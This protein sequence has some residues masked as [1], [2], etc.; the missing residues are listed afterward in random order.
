[1]TMIPAY[2]GFPSHIEGAE[3]Q[4][5]GT[6]NLD[7]LLLNVPPA[8]NYACEKCFTWANMN[9][10]TDYLKTDEWIRIIDEGY[11]NGVKVLGVL[12]EGEPLMYCGSLQK[13]VDLRKV[14]DYANSLGM[15][16]IIATNGSLLDQELSHFL[17][18]RNVTLA[19]SLDTLDS[20]EYNSFYKG[21]AN[22]EVLLRNIDYARKV[23]REDIYEKNGHRV[24]RLG[25]HMTVTSKNLN[26]INDIKN[27]CSDDLYFDCD[28]VAKVGIANEHPEIYGDKIESEYDLCVRASRNG[29]QPMVITKSSCGS[30]ACCFFYYG[31]AVGYEGEVML[32]THAVETKNVLGNVRQFNFDE[33]IAKAKT[34]RDTYF[35]DF[36]G[37]HCIIRNPKYRDFLKYIDDFRVSHTV[38]QS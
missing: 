38:I 2:K 10:I 20:L 12:G 28:H 36:S 19:I 23:F 13:K 29:A 5:Y 17:Y 16:T 1:M 4:K 22:L 27:Y 25:V 3:K 11:R 6:T 14:I 31:F 8:C 21:Q 32:D 24:Y 34:F 7:Y 30:D 35:S 9:K 15:I 26:Y 37:H 33:L 18:E